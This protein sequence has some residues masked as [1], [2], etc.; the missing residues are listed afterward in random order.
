[1]SKKPLEIV[2]NKFGDMVPLAQ[3]WYTGQGSTTEVA[4]DFDDTL[5]YHKMFEYKTARAYFRGVKTGR[6]YC[7]FMDD[8][9]NILKLGRLIN[10]EVTGKFKFTK[11]GQGQGI[12]L[13]LHS[14]DEARLKDMRD[15]A[16]KDERTRWF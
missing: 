14:A 10:N 5:V 6:Y 4:V 15:E 9:D 1:M 12:K 3:S 7:M 11:R 13:I 16:R 2:F 8:F